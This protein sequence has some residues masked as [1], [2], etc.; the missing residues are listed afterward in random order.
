M[1]KQ[2]HPADTK[3]I[4]AAELSFESLKACYKILLKTKDNYKSR[5]TV[6]HFMERAFYQAVFDCPAIQTGLYTRNNTN[7]KDH[8]MS[9]QILSNYIFDH[10]DIYLKDFDHFFSIF[11]LCCRTIKV[12]PDENMRVREV[13]KKQR[14]ASV[15]AYEAA[16]IDL[17]YEGAL[18]DNHKEFLDIPEK[19]TE[20]EIGFKNY[21]YELTT[22]KNFSVPLK[23]Q[24]GTL[25]KFL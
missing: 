13:K 22:N 10:A 9:P 18:I 21:N 25:E 12:S 19:I 1:G 14:L 5:K 3:R 8:Y 20:W 4:I 7:T 11:E 24:V 16:G 23:Y 15:E 17:Y 2:H 6:L